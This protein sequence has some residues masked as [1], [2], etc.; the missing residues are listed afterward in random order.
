[1]GLE[2]YYGKVPP[3]RGSPRFV[4]MNAITLDFA[5]CQVIKSLISSP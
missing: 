1:M 3:R 5:F 2:K 4:Y